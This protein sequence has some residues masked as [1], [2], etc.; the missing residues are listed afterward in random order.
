MRLSADRTGFPLLVVPE[1]ELEVHL[2]PITKLQFEQFLTESNHFDQPWYDQLLRLN[3]K[4]GLQTFT[5]KTREQLFITG[6]LPAEARAFAQWLGEGF[7]LPTLAEWRIVYQALRRIRFPDS[8]LLFDWAIDPVDV[9]LAHLFE[10]YP[11]RWLVDI[12]LMRHGLVEW[13]HQ[14]ETWVGVGAPRAVFHPNLWD[15]LRNIIKPHQA[16]ERLSYFG[17]RLVRRGQWD[18]AQPEGIYLF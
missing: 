18:V 17:F 12:A 10:H 7:D 14:N 11:S 4:T 2:L 16:E 6:I 8:A 15:P 3:P 13:V 9:I 1:V 5:P